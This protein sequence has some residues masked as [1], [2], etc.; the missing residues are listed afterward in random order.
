MKTSVFID[1]FNFYYGC[2]KNWD[3]PWCHDFLG[4]GPFKWLDFRSL[5]TAMLPGDTVHRIHYCTATVRGTPRDRDKPV[6]QQTYL[7]ALQGYCKVQV[8]L[9]HFEP[10]DKTGML[11]TP[12]P[13]KQ[14]TPCLAGLVQVSVREEKG[15]DVNLATALLRDAF[16][17]DFEKAIVIS[18]DS[19]LAGAIRVVRDDAKRVVHVVSPYPSV[20]NELK[21]AATLSSVL[22][23]QLIPHCQ[24]PDQVVLKRGAV[25]KR[26]RAW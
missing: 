2:Y 1:G 6:R 15:S 16:L 24:L 13:C 26:P 14:P 18:N 19:D 4:N 5:A 23:K 3:D 22:D 25:L 20:V 21:K 7:R 9:G 11:K 10:R 12:L 8:H 17:G